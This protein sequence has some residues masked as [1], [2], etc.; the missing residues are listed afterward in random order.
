MR[1]C[2]VLVH[3]LILAV[4][5]GASP[6]NVR[7]CAASD[8]S[9]NV[10]FMTGYCTNENFNARAAWASVQKAFE[11]S[12]IFNVTVVNIEDASVVSC[13]AILR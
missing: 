8:C 6:S 4:A 5:E 3:A 2:G 11:S 7:V 13:T 1:L 10:L 9:K 12:D